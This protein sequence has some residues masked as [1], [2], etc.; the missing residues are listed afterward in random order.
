[1]KVTS[2]L[3]ATLPVNILT[4]STHADKA[5]PYQMREA[6]G[7]R[8]QKCVISK[9]KPDKSLSDLDKVTKELSVKDI[10]DILFEEKVDIIQGKCYYKII[11]DFLSEPI[12]YKEVFDPIVEGYLSIV[13][14]LQEQI[15]SLLMDG[16]TSES[17]NDFRTSTATYLDARLTSISERTRILI[18][19][20]ETAKQLETQTGR[21]TDLLYGEIKENGEQ[22][23]GIINTVDTLSKKVE[24]IDTTS[25]Q[26]M[27]SI[28][29]LVGIFSSIII[30]I[31]SL[32]ATSSA[33]LSSANETSVLI[34]FVVPAGIITLS[35]CALTALVRSITERRNIDNHPNTKCTFWNGLKYNFKKWSTWVTIVLITIVVVCGTIYYCQ[36]KVDDATHYLI[37]ATPIT[38]SDNNSSDIEESAP[39]STKNLVIVQEVILPSG[40][41]HLKTIPCNQE[42][43]HPD[44]CVYYCLIHEK[45]E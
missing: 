27:P 14:K 28:I 31:L 39:D 41:K 19:V 33:W 4:A 1:M 18:T 30:V 23:S 15:Q 20:N 6:L 2:K 36:N 40:E 22:E 38:E 17:D 11:E 37:K 43:I 8:F 35:I 44:G 32:I 9:A 34:A 21:L 42:D 29:S 16:K 26:I 10:N 12:F 45:F 13:K 24:A 7:E 25:D 3:K 5:N